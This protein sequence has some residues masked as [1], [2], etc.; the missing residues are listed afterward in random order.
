MLL[1][2]VGRM[3]SSK[4]GRVIISINTPLHQ[5]NNS[6][7]LRGLY[8]LPFV[9]IVLVFCASRFRSVLLW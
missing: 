4:A 1:S 3:K 6:K 7:A 9:F 2:L 8:P 5:R